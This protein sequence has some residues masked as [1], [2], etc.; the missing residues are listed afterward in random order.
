MD[1]I[2]EGKDIKTPEDLH[3]ALSAGLAFP[4][5][6]GRN[7]DALWDCL[8]GWLT[9]PVTIIWKDYAASREALGDYAQRAVDLIRDAT[10]EVDG[11]K[12]RV[13]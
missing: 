13:E 6:Y 2:I 4:E 3:D 10:Q 8:T 5:Y 7:L 12:L 1:V 9:T 11:L